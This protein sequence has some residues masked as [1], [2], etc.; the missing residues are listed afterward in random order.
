MPVYFSIVF[1][2]FLLA[3]RYPMN[4]NYCYLSIGTVLLI[5]FICDIEDNL[6]MIFFL[7]PNIRI[8]DV[9]EVTFFVNLLIMFISLK[10][11]L[12][13]RRRN[14]YI[15]LLVLSYYGIEALNLRYYFNL[16]FNGAVLDVIKVGIDIFCCVSLLNCSFSK[17]L[18]FLCYDSLCYGVIC[19]ALVYFLVNP[20]GLHRLFSTGYRLGAYGNDPN[21]YSVYILIAFSGFLYK[22]AAVGI[23]F[24]DAVKIMILFFIGMMTASK[25]TGLCFA[26]TC[27]L[28]LLFAFRKMNANVWKTIMIISILFCIVFLIFD[29]QTIYLIKRVVVRFAERTGKNFM[30]NI[31]SRRTDTLIKYFEYVKSNPGVLIVGMGIGYAQ[32]FKTIYSMFVAHNTYV[33]MIMSWGVLGSLLL[34]VIFR[35]LINKKVSLRCLE[36]QYALLPVI[37]LMVVIMALSCLSSDMFWYLFFLAIL[38]FKSD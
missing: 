19:S 36:I 37:E 20:G 27:V 18:K 21:Y 11:I 35:K 17:D 13:S 30:G 38:P 31:T 34:C 12:L 14:V 29:E 33:D 10:S 7:L 5:S 2:A 4:L 28:Y 8:L 32:Y 23:N 16:D 24:V 3:N 26:G 9:S 15:Y 6:A 22:M 25:M 1:V